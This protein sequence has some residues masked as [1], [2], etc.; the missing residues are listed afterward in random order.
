[1]LV[2]FERNYEKFSL[3]EVRVRK[4][5]LCSPAAELRYS[6][7]DMLV[8]IKSGFWDGIKPLG[9]RRQA[10]WGGQRHSWK[11][12]KETELQSWGS[13]RH[14]YRNSLTV[15][16]MGAVCICPWPCISSQGSRGI[17]HDVA[18]TEAVL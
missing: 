8:R 12:R 11:E 3:E 9:C 7:W 2:E 4:G 13:N 5:G 6:V 10:V 14:D 15:M 17:E 18:S 16:S 1:M